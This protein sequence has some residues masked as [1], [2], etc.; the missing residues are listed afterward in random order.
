[1]EK[2]HEW[3]VSCPSCKK[4]YRL[5]KI[6]SEEDYS[7]FLNLENKSDHKI[8]VNCPNPICNKKISKLASKYNS[9]LTTDLGL[10]ENKKKIVYLRPETCQGIFINFINIQN[11]THK[12]LPF[13]IGQIGK[14]FRKEITLH[15]GVFRTYEF[16]QMELEFF[17]LE[18]EREK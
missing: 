16:E 18:K 2:F 6:F 13:G 10:T 11:S 4:T 8:E 12:K 14:S 15:R 17:C 9:L 7:K 1:L 5:D 3:F